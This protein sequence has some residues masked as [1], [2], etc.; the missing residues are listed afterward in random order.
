MNNKQ[1][2]FIEN[3]IKSPAITLIELTSNCNHNCYGCGNVFQRQNTNI[4]VSFLKKFLIRNKDNIFDVRLTGG[5]PTLHPNLGEIVDFLENLNLR[6]SILTNGNWKSCKEI[7]DLVTNKK[8]FSGFL[9]SLHGANA[10]DH[11]SFVRKKGAFYNITKNIKEL[12]DVGFYVSTNT[13]LNSLTVDYIDKISDLSSRLG[14]NY[15]VF[16][17]YYGANELYQINPQ[18]LKTSVEKITN[19]RINGK[20]VRLGNCTPK[21]FADCD[22]DGCPA[23]NF[24]VTIDPWFNVRPCNHSPMIIG[25]LQ[26]ESLY[27]IWH[28]DKMELWRNL[29]PEECLGCSYNYLCAGGCRAEALLNN[30][31]KDPLIQKTSVKGIKFPDL[32]LYENQQFKSNYKRRA[33]NFGELLYFEGE[34]ILVNRDA[35]YLL[36]DLDYGLKLNQLIKRYGHD[37]LELIA[38]LLLRGFIEYA[39]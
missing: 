23:G 3:R 31:I 10:N 21:C 7:I 20:N 5:E 19:D 34:V 15:S 26:K 36:N 28:S 11:D 30:S 14:A 38:E 33:E 4:D 39:I 6:Y 1:I 35:I 22:S 32:N 37:S 2:S 29:I 9:I 18:K 25:N 16:N 27:N 13:I 8:N 12:T 17:R 24:A